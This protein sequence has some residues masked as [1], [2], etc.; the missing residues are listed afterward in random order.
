MIKLINNINKSKNYFP[1]EKINDIEEAILNT[2]KKIDEFANNEKNILINEIE[3]II[4]NLNDIKNNYINSFNEKTN[5]IN[6]LKSFIFI[7]I[8]ILSKKT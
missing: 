8:Y 1:K 6:P 3:K 5:F 7:K 2:K 4:N